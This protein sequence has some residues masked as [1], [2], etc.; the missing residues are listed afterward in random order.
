MKFETSVLIRQPVGDVFDYVSEPINFSRWNSAVRSVRELSA[1]TDG[2]GATYL[3]E[4]ELPSGRAE[5]ELQ[6]LERDRPNGFTIRTTSGPTPFF[7][8]YRFRDEGDA[9]LLELSAEVEL[10]GLAGALGPLASRAVKQGV[11][12]NFADLKRILEPA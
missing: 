2:V 11:D 9:T 7:Y 6:V 10:G 5:N 4:R 3:M 1:A 8:R 12:S